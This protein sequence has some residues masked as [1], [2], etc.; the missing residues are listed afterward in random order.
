M[1]VTKENAAKFE[2]TLLIDEH[3][4]KKIDDDN[5]DNKRGIRGCVALL[6][7]ID[8]YIDAYPCL[9]KSKKQGY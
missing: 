9:S 8:I 2:A 3:R 5:H 4:E 7:L 6:Y 1:I